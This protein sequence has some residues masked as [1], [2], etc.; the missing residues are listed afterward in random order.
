MKDSRTRPRWAR[1]LIAPLVSCALLTT[2]CASLVDWKYEQTQMHR[3]RAAYK[4]CGNPCGECYPHDYRSGWI[5]GYYDT[6]TGGDGCP[7]SIAPARYWD[8]KQILEDCDN[9]RHAYYSGWQDGAAAAS[10]CPDTHYLKVW[11]SCE[12]EFPRCEQPCC[13][14]SGACGCPTLDIPVADGNGHMIE[15]ISDVPIGTAHSLT[16]GM[17]VPVPMDDV[18]DEPVATDD[19]A[20]EDSEPDAQEDAPESD[21]DAAADAVEEDEPQLDVS[22]DEDSDFGRGAEIIPAAPAEFD[23]ALYR[24][25][26][27]LKIKTVG[28]TSTAK[29]AAPTSEK[30]LD[31]LRQQQ[32]ART[33]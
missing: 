23:E 19:V 18:E 10:R 14:T 12:C 30:L 9:R 15:V 16:D 1:W 31:A 11:E 7:P 20:E 13:P 22:D 29:P 5:D 24:P 17:I 33:H 28:F 8:P 3:A 32:Q 4:H 27:Q 2:G 21:V 26:V 6:L 25:N